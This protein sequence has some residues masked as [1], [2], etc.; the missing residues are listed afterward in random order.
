V[1]QPEELAAAARASAGVPVQTMVNRI[2]DAAIGS[3]PVARDDI[4][5]LA[6]RARG[7]RPSP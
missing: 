1:W 5:L 3:V 6:V 4:A 2:L 7:A